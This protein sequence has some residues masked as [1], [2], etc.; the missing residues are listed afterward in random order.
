VRGGD[1]NPPQVSDR[2]PG[3]GDGARQGRWAPNP[4]CAGVISRGRRRFPAAYTRPQMVMI[5]HSQRLAV[6]LTRAQ[7]RA[8][9]GVLVV[10]LAVAGWAIG[11]SSAAPISSH[12]CV[13]VVV[14]SSTGGGLLSHCG[15]AARTWCQTEFAASD[16]LARRIQV[17]CR[18]AGLGPRRD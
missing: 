11:R 13:N 7:K 1:T 2:P 5:G 10:M 15:A 16:P 14:A 17:Q 12:G 8:I 9:A 6:P 3:C 18:L 4:K